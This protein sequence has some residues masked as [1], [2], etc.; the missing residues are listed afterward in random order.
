M[1]TMPTQPIIPTAESAVWELIKSIFLWGLLAVILIYSFVRFVKQHDSLLA[2]LRKTRVVN[3]LV[4]A[5]QWLYKNVD[6]ARGGLA[7]AF[8][9]GWQ[10]IA[11]RFDKQRAQPILNWINVR[12][13][14]P[15]RR[16]YF[17]YLAMIRRAS[18]QGL[19]R[20]PSQTPA[21]YAA[22]L[23]QALP[24]ASEDIDSITEAFIQARY[25]RR[26][27]AAQDADFVKTTWERIRKAFQ[28][29]AKNDKSVRD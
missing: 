16:I 26:E 11:S 5:W 4:L 14:D 20:T 25:S 1:P 12:A 10:N 29:K 8:A 17:F 22:T 6:K 15:R 2:A 23:E 24:T 28:S 3:W 27:V 21:E 13:L 19:T 18:E 7:H 9:D